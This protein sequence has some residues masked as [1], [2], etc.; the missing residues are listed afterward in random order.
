MIDKFKYPAVE[1]RCQPES[2]L[3]ERIQSFTVSE[4][5]DTLG[6]G[7]KLTKQ[8]AALCCAVVSFIA[9]ASCASVAHP[10]VKKDGALYDVPYGSHWMQKLDVFFPPEGSERRGL[11]VMVHGGGWM[12]GDKRE[13]EQCAKLV[14]SQGYVTLTPNYRLALKVTSNGPTIADML[15]DLDGVKAFAGK[16]QADFDCDASKMAFIGF[17]AGGHLSLMQAMTRNENGAIKCCAS[18]S[19]V[20]DLLD[21]VFHGNTV[22]ILKGD[23]IAS[24]AVGRKL[25]GENPSAEE[26]FRR[27]SPLYR[28][29]GANCPILI[30]HGTSDE[31]VPYGQAVAMNARLEGQGKQVAFASGTGL[32]HTFEQEGL[33][34]SITRENLLPLLESTLR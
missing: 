7:K 32:G 22:G 8:M 6:Q 17:S 12:G 13:M 11:V 4:V 2:P 31:V 29:E 9:M 3:T 18:Y 16:R 1:S 21:P 14:A 24:F 19:G 25:D 15:D 23:T 5:P 26:E 20:T 33:L 27:W 34:L 10:N 28:T 30:V